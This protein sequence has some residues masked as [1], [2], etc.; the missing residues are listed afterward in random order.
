MDVRRVA[1]RNYSG[2][3]I[4]LSKANVLKYWKQYWK[5]SCRCFHI[6]I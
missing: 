2:D 5:S 3:A 4:N 1:V 6:C